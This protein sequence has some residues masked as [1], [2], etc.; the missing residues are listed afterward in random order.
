VERNALRKIKNRGEEV[1]LGKDR[2]ER[3]TGG[4]KP[5]IALALFTSAYVYHRGLSMRPFLTGIDGEWMVIFHD[6]RTPIP[7][8]KLSQTNVI[9]ALGRNTRD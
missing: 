5:L 3:K 4:R 6:F 9:N 7:I 1:R 8:S 2:K